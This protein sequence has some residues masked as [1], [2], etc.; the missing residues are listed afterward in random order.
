MVIHQQSLTELAARVRN[1]ELSARE[2]AAHHL[3]RA[4]TL[5][6]DL[7]AF[8]RLDERALARAEQV[9]A[10]IAAGEDPGPLA[11]VPI[12]LKDLIDQEGTTTT[13]GSAFFRHV[14]Q[15]S[16]TV[17]QRLEDAGAVILGR[18]GLHEFAFGFSSE[19]HWFGPVRNPWDRSTSPGGSSGGSAVAVA[20][21]LA[22]GAVGTDTGGSIRVP[23]A[24]CGIVGLKVTHGRIP[25]TGVFPL[26]SS[27]DTVGPMARDIDDTAAL[28]TA[29][30][31]HDPEDPWSVDRAG[32]SDEPPIG[33]EGLR[34]GIPQPW[35]EK[36][37]LT[38]EVANEFSATLDNL[39]QLGASVHEI[40]HPT[41]EPGQELT[42]LMNGEVASVHRHWF[43][44]PEKP[45][46]PEVA[47]RMQPAMEVTV[48]AYLSAQP[49]RA[50]LRNAVE[51]AF[52]TV[53]VLATPA[54]AA[55]RK[56]IG[57]PSIVVNGTPRSYRLVLSW[58]SALVNHMGVPA[59]AMPLRGAGTPPASLQLIGPWWSE[60]RLLALGRAL[61]ITGV[62]GFTPPPVW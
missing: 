11:G 15:R 14:A 7:N 46:G 9:D 43:A 16:A 17:V 52:D 20:A 44:D 48:D 40:R 45:Y 49:W 33:I 25:L 27:V 59:L 50:G 34:V 54:V 23:A 28:Y 3:E 47:E 13:C 60:H 29:M 4:Q 22:P 18:T 6:D 12:G 31:G 24:L 61:E 37:P 1:G 32:D 58:F 19:N 5:Q 51:S 8:T 53:D 55:T 38:D 2:V 39:R 57:D 41:L 56:V 26:S 42:D 10:Q 30:A 62:T 36:A 35:M 21:G